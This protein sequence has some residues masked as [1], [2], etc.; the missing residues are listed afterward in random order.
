LAAAWPLRRTGPED[1]RRSFG[2][3][4]RAV[5]ER[6]ERPPGNIGRAFLRYVG[7]AARRLSQGLVSRAAYRG[8]S[9]MSI[10]SPL[11]CYPHRGCERQGRKAQ[12]DLIAFFNGRRKFYDP[13]HGRS[14][15]IGGDGKHLLTPLPN[16]LHSVLRSL[17][18][19][20]DHL[21]S[22]FDEFVAAERICP[23][24]ARKSAPASPAFAFAASKNSAERAARSAPDA[25]YLG[26]VRQ[27]HI[28]PRPTSA[29]A[30]G[31]WCKRRQASPAPSASQR[32]WPLFHAKGLAR[33]RSLT[34]LPSRRVCLSFRRP[35]PADRP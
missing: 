34:P 33:P 2:S 1:R 19:I 12:E 21:S 10:K 6:A 22:A 26:S 31:G 29:D 11:C 32:P 16:C 17:N 15:A 27:R 4:D 24:R 28:R 8:R 3:N 14:C 13:V 18:G 25:G 9:R 35:E 7:G 20:S 5:G 23:A 30:I